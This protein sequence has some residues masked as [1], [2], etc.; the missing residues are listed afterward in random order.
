[1][2]LG[3]AVYHGSWHCPLGRTTGSR[4]FEDGGDP[5]APCRAHRNQAATAAFSMQQLGENCQNASAGR[6]K[7]MAEGD[8]RALDVEFRSVDRAKRPIP[9]EPVAAIVVRFPSLQG[10]EHL[11]RECLVNLIL[12]KILQCQVTL[13]QEVAD[14]NGRGHQKPLAR[15]V[16]DGGGAPNRQIGLNRNVAL[17]RPFL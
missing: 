15:D 5:H 8:A 17:R 3:P 4:S 6:G 13:F 7:G 9:P 1:M 16:V 12:I 2:A 10:G 11:G 14:G